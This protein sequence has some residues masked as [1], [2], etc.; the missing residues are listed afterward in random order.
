MI[1]EDVIVIIVEPIH[2]NHD[3]KI[4]DV[5]MISPRSNHS[6]AIILIGRFSTIPPLSHHDHSKIPPRSCQDFINILPEII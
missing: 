1:L 3:V 2:N 6:L 4:H 5:I